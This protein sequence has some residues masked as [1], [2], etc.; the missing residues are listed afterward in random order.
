MKIVTAEHFPQHRYIVSTLPS[1]LVRIID[2][3]IGND[4]DCFTLSAVLE[5]VRTVVAPGLYR[6]THQENPGSSQLALHHDPSEGAH[7]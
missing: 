5:K 2:P 7:E 3:T 6:S 1:S 4:I